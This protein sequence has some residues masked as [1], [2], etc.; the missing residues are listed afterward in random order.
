LNLHTIKD[1][2]NKDRDI[3]MTSHSI[4]NEKL[5]E[6]G[7]HE[8]IFEYIESDGTKQLL[9]F[10]PFIITSLSGGFPLIIDEFGSEMHPMLTKRIFQSYNN[11][12]V[13][14]Q[15]IVSTHTTELMSSDLL[16][17][18]QID[19]VEKDKYGRS[20]LYTLAELKGVRNNT[21]FESDYLQGKYGA[22]PFLRNLEEFAKMYD[23]D[24]EIKSETGYLQ[25]VRFENPAVI[26][27]DGRKNIGIVLKPE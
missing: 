15:L 4:Y 16:R 5:E 22:I 21:N 17:R 12:K 10:S 25:H 19:F 11:E 6:I 7:T 2:N 14:S 24:I 13:A 1:E 8:N 9:Y 27:I 26:K 3:L 23:E 18:D 20:Y